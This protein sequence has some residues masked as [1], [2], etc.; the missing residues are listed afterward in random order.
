MYQLV[1]N[2]STNHDN[3]VITGG[4]T[5]LPFSC[6]SQSHI[7]AKEVRLWLRILTTKTD[8][9]QHQSCLRELCHLCLILVTTSWRDAMNPFFHM[10]YLRLKELG[11]FKVIENGEK[12]F[13]LRTT[14]P[15]HFPRT[16][17]LSIYMS[18][19]IAINQR[20]RIKHVL[21]QKVKGL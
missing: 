14:T 2:E 3:D 20:E 4:D 16:M 12:E 6:Q 21:Q 17:D 5:A 1:V 7:T 10:L 19:K 8:I 11:Y 15:F 9:T 13:K 18:T